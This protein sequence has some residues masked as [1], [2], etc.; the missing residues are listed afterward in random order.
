[1][2]VTTALLCSSPL[3]RAA[4][5]YFSLSF[6]CISLQR[7]QVFLCFAPLYLC[8]RARLLFTVNYGILNQW[9]I[10]VLH[11]DHFATCFQPFC[12]KTKD[13][14]FF[15]GKDKFLRCS[16]Q[17]LLKKYDNPL[18]SG[19][20]SHKTSKLER[21]IKEEILPNPNVRSVIF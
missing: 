7:K 19:A 11:H 21:K 17:S 3:G 2:V 10:V 9:S 20:I 5:S 16:P 15:K 12:S 6:D 13:F 8:A 14:H 4:T 18:K 1:M